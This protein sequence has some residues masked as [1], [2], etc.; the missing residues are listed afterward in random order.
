[1][2]S[3]SPRSCKAVRHWISNV[4]QQLADAIDCDAHCLPS[5]PDRIPV[6]RGNTR[7]RRLDNDA[8]HHMAVKVV[9]QKQARSAT[10]YV[11]ASGCALAESTARDQHKK[12]M[13]NYHWNGARDFNKVSQISLAA[14]CS[15]LGGQ[16]T[17]TCGVYSWRLDKA[18]WL[19]P[20]ALI[21]VM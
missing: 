1:M 3:P 4:I 11:K 16:E 15:R 8:V 5:V 14:D 6:L 10:S 12:T 7:A 17:L 20:Q 9:Q 21:F 19:P 18:M 13:S 2:S